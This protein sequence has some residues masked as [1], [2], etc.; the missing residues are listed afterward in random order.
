MVSGDVSDETSLTAALAGCQSVVFAAST[1]DYFGAGAVDRDGVLLTA[2]CTHRHRLPF[3]ISSPP[4]P[5]G[6]GF[7]FS[8]F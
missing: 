8:S 2:K 4:S 7:C 5:A 1:S 6:R 3:P